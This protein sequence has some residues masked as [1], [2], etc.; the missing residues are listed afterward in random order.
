MSKP[1][2]RY[3]TVVIPFN[4]ECRSENCQDVCVYLRPETNGIQVES[5]MLR[6][7]Q[8]SSFYRD[9]VELVY[10]AN[11][12]GSF[13]WKKRIIEKHYHLKILF[14]KRGRA[15]FTDYMRRRFSEYFNV[16][17]EKASVWG[18]FQ[19][20]KHL[21]YTR[22]KLFDIWV[23]PEDMLFLNGQTIKRVQEH[24]IINYD[25]PA[26]L[27]KN[28]G[29][30]DMA[31]MILRTDL[32]PE[33]VHKLMMEM[34]DSLKSQGLLSHGEAFTRVFHFSRSPFEQILDGIGFIYNPDGTH[35]DLRSINFYT[36]L[37]R[38]GLTPTEIEKIIQYPIFCFQD[39]E[40]GYS[41]KTI[42][43]ASYGMGYDEAYEKLISASGQVL[44]S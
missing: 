6:T 39:E 9:R 5:A 4:T 34:V 3:P 22:R 20:M 23:P 30:T 18:A 41:E 29:D 40:E 26:I 43:T 44:L 37:L 10:L 21:G 42:Y 2:V 11:L 36:F 13:V 7:I 32:P 33:S 24:F 28:H 16:P 15:L 14:A 38:R 17:F 12:P 35:I 27:L 1:P 8:G 19:A 31:V 25:V